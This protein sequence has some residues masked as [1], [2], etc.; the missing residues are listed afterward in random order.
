MAKMVEMRGGLYWE[1]VDHVCMRGVVVALP[2]SGQALHCGWL[3]IA[4][5]R[6][7]RAPIG[8]PRSSPHG[9]RRG[10]ALRYELESAA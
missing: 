2:A 4:Q 6:L 7:S 3:C 5:M 9:Q 1:V 10:Q 8:Y